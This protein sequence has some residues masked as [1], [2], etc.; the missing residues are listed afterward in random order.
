MSS[1]TSKAFAL[2]A[3]GRSQDASTPTSEFVTLSIGHNSHQ[4]PVPKL[5]PLSKPSWEKNA[6]FRRLVHA[7]RGQIQSHSISDL[8][9][10][11]TS[12]LPTDTNA[13]LEEAL[14]VQ[15]K[16]QASATCLDFLQPVGFL[17]AQ[18]KPMEPPK[19]M[20]PS[21]RPAGISYVHLSCT[22]HGNKVDHRVTQPPF[23]FD[24]CLKLRQSRRDNS[25]G[26]ITDINATN[27]PLKIWF[28]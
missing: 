19:S 17:N 10:A 28:C 24:F 3:K 21:D 18:G 15:D 9:T 27:V 23:S 8:V 4:V 6:C 26:V 13:A 25:T 1:P 20:E 14:S 5:V 12:Q 22:L 7:I 2:V 16:I 11:V